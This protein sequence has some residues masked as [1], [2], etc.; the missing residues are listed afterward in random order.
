MPGAAQFNT[1]ALTEKR[2]LVTGELTKDG[3]S[4]R[5]LAGQ[6][7]GLTRTHEHP[8]GTVLAYYTV[9]EG[10]VRADHANADHQTPAAVT[11]LE[12][13][14]D[15]WEGGTL[16][17]SGHWGALDVALAGTDD[18]D[19]E[20]RDAINAAFAA[21]N[22]EQGPVVASVVAN[23]VVVTNRDKGKGTWLH[24]KHATVTTAFGA[25]GTGSNGTDPKVRV[26]R[27]T[28]WLL[29]GAGAGQDFLVDTI[30]AGDFDTSE[31]SGLTAEARAVLEKA[32]SQ[33]D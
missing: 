27:Q 5:L 1:D 15:D 18:T 24:V 22:P 28:A 21:V 32:G 29:D 20:V 12:T 13:A 33:F 17:I 9:G 25:A 8:P 19:A 14:D 3:G 16:N 11:A 6:L 30:M 31:L 23:R 7:S 2:F 26:T 4:A 10:Y